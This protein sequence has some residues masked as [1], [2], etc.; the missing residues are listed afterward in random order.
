MTADRHPDRAAGLHE[1]VGDLEAA[2]TGAD[3]EDATRRQLGRVPVVVGV[4][5]PDPGGN[6]SATAG[7]RGRPNAPLATTTAS[8]SRGPVG[9]STT[10]PPDVARTAVT[11]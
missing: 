2:L 11:S 1:L 10:K 8:A 5:R 6:R 9:V 4:D 3:D 7:I